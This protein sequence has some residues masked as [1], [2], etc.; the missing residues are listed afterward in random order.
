MGL[1]DLYAQL[2]ACIILQN[3]NFCI[4]TL[5]LKICLYFSNT[6]GYNI[7]DLTKRARTM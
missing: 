6:F 7:Y 4:L 1:C 2:R 3:F 5:I